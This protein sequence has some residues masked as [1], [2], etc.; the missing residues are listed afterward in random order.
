MNEMNTCQ[1]QNSNTEAA[2][3][4]AG[5]ERRRKRRRYEE[6]AHSI[7][8]PPT[9]D[10]T[11][12]LLHFLS[13]VSQQTR[14]RERAVTAR[15]SPIDR[16]E[17]SR[18]RQGERDNKQTYKHTPSTMTST[19]ETASLPTRTQRN[20]AG[21]EGARGLFFFNLKPLGTPATSIQHIVIKI[22]S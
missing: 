5:E 6:E 8:H 19:D 14:E 21:V 11:F 10:L 9:I 16:S 15:L 4:K 17:Q 18:G 12:P 1:M 22:T 20:S 2:S 7:K 3:E 13:L